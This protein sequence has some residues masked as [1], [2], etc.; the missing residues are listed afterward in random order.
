MPDIVN[1]EVPSAT[2]PSSLSAADYPRTEGPM[3]RPAA[4][5]KDSVRGLIGMAR[6]AFST[7]D[8]IQGAISGRNGCEQ[9][10]PPPPFVFSTRRY[11]ISGLY[12]S[13]FFDRQSRLLVITAIPR[14]K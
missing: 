10:V 5:M 11:S 7:L 3:Y 4:Q 13:E 12:T 1:V 9:T 6:Q 8:A 2:V 14:N